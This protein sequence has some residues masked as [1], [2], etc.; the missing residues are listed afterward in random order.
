MRGLKARTLVGIALL[1]LVIGAAVWAL[2]I[3]MRQPGADDRA[4]EREAGEPMVSLHESVIQH[5]G[6]GSGGWR[7]LVERM[8]LAAGGRSVSAVGLREGL[9]YD[10]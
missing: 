7:L 5:G 9:I 10:A 4:G 8:D 1:V 6:A 2:L 3:R